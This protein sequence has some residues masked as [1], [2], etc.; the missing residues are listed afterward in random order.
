MDVSNLELTIADYFNKDK[1]FS[2]NIEYGIMVYNLTKLGPETYTKKDL[3]ENNIKD[4]VLASA[5]CYQLFNLK[6]LITKNI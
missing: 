5:S 6:K 1:F 4:Y 3:D 2:S